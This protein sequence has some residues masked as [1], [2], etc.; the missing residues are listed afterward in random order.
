MKVKLLGMAALKAKYD[1]WV[2]MSRQKFNSRTQQPQLS[3][4]VWGENIK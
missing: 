2:R 1:V 3:Y 4:D